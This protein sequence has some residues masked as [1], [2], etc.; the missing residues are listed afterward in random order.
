VRT[1]ARY[2]ALVDG[3][4]ATGTISD[5]GMLYFDVRPSDRYPTL[6]VRLCD[7][8]PRLDDVLLVAGLARALV[9]TAAA[10]V[11]AGATDDDLPDREL[12]QVARWRAARSGLEGDLIDPVTGRPVPARSAVGRLLEHVAPALEATGEAGV[13]RTLADAALTSGTSARR[14]R[15]VVERGGDLADVVN[16]LVAE[17]REVTTA[18]G[19]P[20][21][22]GTTPVRRDVARASG[23][24]RRSREV[25]LELPEVVAP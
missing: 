23:P 4:V 6:E 8:L 15:R 7:A 13:L 3:L 10:E 2:D 18:A 20:S 21:G 24:R 14:Q 9:E 25:V 22:A 19:T 11:V 12:L 17:T 1:A 16:L 5:R